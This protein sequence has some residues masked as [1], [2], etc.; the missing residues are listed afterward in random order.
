MTRVTEHLCGLAAA[1]MSGWKLAKIT[2][3]V[4]RLLARVPGA[5]L[6]H[7]L[8]LAAGV[9]GR[10][11]SW[12]VLLFGYEGCCSR[13]QLGAQ[14]LFCACGKGRQRPVVSYHPLPPQDCWMKQSATLSG[15]MMT[16]GYIAVTTNAVSP[17]SKYVV[18]WSHPRRINVNR[19]SGSSGEQ[20]RRRSKGQAIAMG[21]E[22]KATS[23]RK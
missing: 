15:A 4:L 12:K 19:A 6:V 3:G 22:N 7:G 21:T 8:G 14:T 23:G 2:K 20:H 11:C 5:R 13:A 16:N 9:I 18:V 1:R 17:T 10:F